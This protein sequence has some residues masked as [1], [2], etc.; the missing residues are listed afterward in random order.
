MKAYDLMIKTNHHL[1]RGGAFSDAEKDDIVRELYVNRVTDGRKKTANAFAYP[2]FFIPPYNNGKKLQTIIPMSPKSNII[3]DNAYEFEII[4]LLHMFKPSDEVSHMIE[5]TS[6]R[7]KQ[8]CFGY[9]DCHYADCF[10]AGLTVLRYISFAETDDKNWIKKQISI[11][12][13][14]FSDKRRHNGVQKYFWLILSDMPFDLAEPEILNQ[15][16][17]IIEQLNQSYLIKTGNED[18]LL[19]VMRNTLARLPEYSY[20]N[21]RKPY[22]NKKNGRLCFDMECTE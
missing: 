8:T 4:R 17:L 10:E 7:L 21:N 18:V 5:T 19:C 16:E 6:N 22:I 20:I 13:N 12:N 11:Y 9:N 14:Y 2:K 15:K 3:A 1:I